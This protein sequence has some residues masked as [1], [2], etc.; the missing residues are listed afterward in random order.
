[1]CVAY[2]RA[3][4]LLTL[5]TFKSG[6]HLVRAPFLFPHFTLHCYTLLCPQSLLVVSWQRIHK[7]LIVTAAHYEIF[8]AQPNSFLAISSQLFCQLPIP[9]TLSILILVRVRVR[10]TLRL[11]VY[12]QSLRLGDKP[13]ETH[14]Q[15]FYF[16]TDR[17]RL[18]SSCNILSDEMMGLS[19]TIATGQQLSHSQARVP[20]DS[21]PHFTVS[22]LRLPQPGGPVPVF[23]SPGTGWTGYTPRYDSQGYGGGIRPCLHTGF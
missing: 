11:A 3:L 20:W 15:I 6:L 14:D 12:R 8:L 9:E 5:Y 2:R 22:D 13:L 17:L 7:S 18:Y 10:V 1:V 4:D 21:W 19:F 23:L 16:P